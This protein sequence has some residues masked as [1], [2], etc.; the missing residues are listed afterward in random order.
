[1]SSPRQ[2]LTPDSSPYVPNSVSTKVH[3]EHVEE[4]DF[5]TLAVMAEARMNTIQESHDI[6]GFHSRLTRGERK[7]THI[8]L[9]R[10][11]WES[12]VSTCSTLSCLVISH[13]A[14]KTRT[15]TCLV[16][17][18]VMMLGTNASS[19]PLSASVNGISLP[20]QRSAS[21]RAI[22]H[23]EGLLVNSF[24]FSMGIP[25]IMIKTAFIVRFSSVGLNEDKAQDPIANPSKRSTKR[26]LSG[27]PSASPRSEDYIMEHLNDFTVHPV[28]DPLCDVMNDYGKLI[29]LRLLGVTELK[30]VYFMMGALVGVVKH[31]HGRPPQGA[32][33]GL[34][35]LL[36]S[37]LFFRTALEWAAFRQL[38][39]GWLGQREGTEVGGSRCGGWQVYGWFA[40]K[41]KKRKKKKREGRKEQGTSAERRAWLHW[42]HTMPI[43][44]L[45]KPSPNLL[46][47]THAPTFVRLPPPPPPC[48]HGCA[49][50]CEAAI[51]PS[52]PRGIHAN[53]HLHANP[54]PRHLLFPYAR[55]STE[56]RTSMRVSSLQW[57]G[58]GISQARLPF[59]AD[60]LAA[61]A[62]PSRRR[63]RSRHPFPLL[64]VAA[65][66]GLA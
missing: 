53:T 49:W 40:E 54:A 11:Q 32:G 17:S 13:H 30:Q 12:S 5:G 9:E 61:A 3:P 34:F 16:F 56:T 66:G 64:Y 2:L 19:I 36:F 39:G 25:I 51:T 22:S 20:R 37:L 50:S 14:C 31:V 60:L 6:N 43:P 4:S 47:H 45:P 52:R 59:P 24:S 41:Q 57:L 33:G 29:H 15:T 62:P 18:G 23:P 35:L 48:W 21:R 42:T 28:V 55:I 27:K 1:M 44:H 38:M 8:D 58:A 65:G 7:G 46:L 63:P 26:L 10:K